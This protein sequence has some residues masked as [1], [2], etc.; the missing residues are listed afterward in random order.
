MIQ[1]IL[2][3]IGFHK[4]I[5]ISKPITGRKNIKHMKD[6][7]MF[8]EEGP[9]ETFYPGCGV[10]PFTRKCSKCSLIQ[11]EHYGRWE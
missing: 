8:I 9:E 11:S 7:V 1:R 10:V 6:G 2:C 4:F 5:D 3:K